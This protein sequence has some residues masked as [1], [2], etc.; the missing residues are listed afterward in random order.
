M[1]TTRKPTLKDVA[2]LAGTSVATASVVLNK[3]QHKFVS[4]G[5]VA[6][7]N[8]AVRQLQYFPNI[9]ARRMKGKSGRFLAIMIPQFENVYFHRIVISAENYANSRGYTLSIFTTYDQE[10][11]E[12]KY[13]ENLI[14]L[15]VDGVLISPAHY[16]SQSVKML[17]AAGI[18]FVVVDRPVSE[19]NYDLVTI[20]YYQAGYRGTQLLLENGHRRIAYFG[21]KSALIGIADRVRGFKDAFRDA[22]LPFENCIWEVDRSPE[23]ARDL[24]LKV[25]KEHHFS[26]IFA[27]HHQIG[28]G[29][30]E[31]LRALGKNV[32]QDYSV[33]LFGNPVWATI[34]NPRYTCIAQPDYEI[35]RKAAELIIDQLENTEHQFDHYL[36]PVETFIRESIESI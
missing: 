31:T 18:P 7:V 11:K 16:S 20:D 9:P 15:Q 4:E 29:I 3:D 34:T 30:I 35:G 19:E 10:D 12:L 8:E 25:L 14:S 28:E 32:P 33:L 17:R 6:R 23:A 13:V 26:A 24:T 36:L 2:R 21:W 22:N 5:L 27:G 1:V